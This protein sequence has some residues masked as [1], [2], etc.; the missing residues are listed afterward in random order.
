M[1]PI[2]I[3]D[4]PN[5]WDLL[6]SGLAEKDTFLFRLEENLPKEISERFAGSCVVDR[7]ILVHVIG[8]ERDPDAEY[9]YLADQRATDKWIV[10]LKGRGH[11]SGFGPAVVFRARY[12]TQIRRGEIL[13]TEVKVI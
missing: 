4:G 2:K 7:V 12:N 8:A 1:A 6:I 11:G 13:S 5:R 10:T 3:V 9:E